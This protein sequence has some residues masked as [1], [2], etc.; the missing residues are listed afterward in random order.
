MMFQK[1]GQM[2]SLSAIASAIPANMQYQHGPGRKTLYTAWRG[3]GRSK[4]IPHQGQQEKARRLRQM[5]K[6]A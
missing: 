6:S 3:V 4:Y 5:E 1:I 2:V